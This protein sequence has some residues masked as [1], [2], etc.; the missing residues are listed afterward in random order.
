MIEIAAVI[1]ILITIPLWLPLV[2]K[3]LSM[4]FQAVFW[5]VLIG[6]VIFLL[7]T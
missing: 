7:L 3:L 1:F 2:I 5:L 4:G 6:V